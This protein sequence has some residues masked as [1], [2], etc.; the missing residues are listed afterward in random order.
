MSLHLIFLHQSLRLAILALLRILNVWLSIMTYS[1]LE[2]VCLFEKGIYLLSSSEE[3]LHILLYQSLE[4]VYVSFQA[5]ESLFLFLLS[6]RCL[7]WHHKLPEPL[8]AHSF[9]PNHASD[10]LED[11]FYFFFESCLC[12]H[13][14]H[15]NGLIGTF[16]SFDLW[17]C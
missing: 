5:R 3:V 10:A 9:R 13:T 15:A 1:C 14:H 11:L 8:G 16:L 6:V 12:G 4:F 2:S 17:S 7:R